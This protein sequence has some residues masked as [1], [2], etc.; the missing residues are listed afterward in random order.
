[1]VKQDTIVVTKAAPVKA[2]AKAELRVSLSPKV[3]YF[4][5]ASARMGANAKRIVREIGA[6]LAKNDAA[7]GALE[8]SGHTDSR[9]SYKYN[10]NLSDKRSQAVMEDLARGGARPSKI[11]AEAFAFT[12][13]VA[14]GKDKASLAQNRRVELVF[15]N[16]SDPNLIEKEIRKIV[17]GETNMVKAK[18]VE[19]IPS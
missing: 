10:L 9:G 2:I 1:V 13:P 11:K 3:V 19:K 4:N 14:T 8:I 12:R 16:V 6:F 15:K 17:E 18:K 7:W 5:T